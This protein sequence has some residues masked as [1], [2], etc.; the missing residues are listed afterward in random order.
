MLKYKITIRPA[1]EDDD[2]VNCLLEEINEENFYLRL[3]SLLDDIRDMK[4]IVGADHCDNEIHI[5]SFGSLKL[6]H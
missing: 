2:P 3:H 1:K 5:F 4:E 6:T